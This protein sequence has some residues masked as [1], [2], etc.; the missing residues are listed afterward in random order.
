MH[1]Y[2]CKAAHFHAHKERCVYLIRCDDRL[3]TT[4]MPFH[5][6]KLSSDALHCFN[7]LSLPNARIRLAS[8]ASAQSHRRKVGS[9]RAHTAPRLIGPNLKPWS[10]DSMGTAPDLGLSCRCPAQIPQSPTL[11]KFQVGVHLGACAAASVCAP[12][13][14]GAHSQSDPPPV[15]C[16]G[17]PGGGGGLKRPRMPARSLPPLGRLW[18]KY[19]PTQLEKYPDAVCVE[20][21]AR[22]VT[23]PKS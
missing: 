18:N 16:N 23:A 19:G 17:G 14:R 3:R 21:R 11:A 10:A 5:D 6:S 22:H 13:T 4:N 12:R 15:G 9:R 7:H 2:T 20:S 8:V 1:A